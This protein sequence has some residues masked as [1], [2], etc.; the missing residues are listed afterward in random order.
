MFGSIPGYWTLVVV[1]YPQQLY[2][3]KYIQTLLNVPWR[4][5]LFRR[6]VKTNYWALPTGF[7]N[8]QVWIEP[9]NLHSP[10]SWVMLMLLVPDHTENPG[11]DICS[12]IIALPQLSALHHF[13]PSSLPSTIFSLPSTHAHL[14]L[15]KPSG[16]DTCLSLS[17]MLSSFFYFSWIIIICYFLSCLFNIPPLPET[18]PDVFS[19]YGC[20][21]VLCTHHL[22]RH[23]ST[24]LEHF[25]FHLS[26]L[27][28]WFILPGLLL[29]GENHVS[30][31]AYPCTQL[32]AWYRVHTI[33]VSRGNGWRTGM[34]WKV[35]STSLGETRY[36]GVLSSLGDKPNIITHL[37]LFWEA[38]E[39]SYIILYLYSLFCH[40][41]H[42]E[43]LI[44]LFPFS[45]P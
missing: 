34:C 28:K 38:G 17:G 14:A 5:K 1:L 23:L 7:L 24:C 40:K 43:I 36:P 44:V 26:F 32:S 27:S 22:W 10:T 13:P 12:F 19:F 31:H 18:F 21:P 8:K 37:L 42:C 3:P 6:L 39:A 33:A 16:L 30:F 25:C 2:S 9:E 35:D 15:P 29:Q 45:F 4:V 11:T 41:C 20:P